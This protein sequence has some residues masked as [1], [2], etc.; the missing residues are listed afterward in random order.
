MLE[1]L[2]R[3][4]AT[5][6]ELA[7]PLAIS[8]PAAHKHVALLEAAR[9]VACEKRGRERVCRLDVR[10]LEGARAWIDARRRLWHARLDALDRHL[11]NGGDE[12]A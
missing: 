9:L 7:R 12:D 3:G 2:S 11:R 10:G 8:L 4:E 6:S 1:R 5:L